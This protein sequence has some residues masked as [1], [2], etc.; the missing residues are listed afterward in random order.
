MI[1]Y[2]SYVIRNSQMEKN[3][4]RWCQGLRQKKNRSTERI[5]ILMEA[6][7]AMQIVGMRRRHRS[8]DYGMGTIRTAM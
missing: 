3:A 1:E 5:L 2:R 8:E 6:G 4:P 7:K